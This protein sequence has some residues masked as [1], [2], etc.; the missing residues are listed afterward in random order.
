MSSVNLE[1]SGTL[2]LCPGSSI[3]F[4]CT[5]IQSQSPFI[6]WRVI[7]ENHPKGDLHFF[8][9]TDNVSTTERFVGNFS[10][11]LISTS[12]L[13]STATLTDGFNLEQ[14]ETMLACSD[15]LS[16]N[17]SP[18]QVENATLI[19]KGTFVYTFVCVSLCLLVREREREG[20]NQ[21]SVSM[22]VFFICD[23][24]RL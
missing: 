2:K 19:L 21:V 12:P 7:D 11:A 18:S 10:I 17:Q 6:V 16:L 24:D 15:T 3:T 4:V 13:V 9:K 22:A 23:N 8:T 5:I 20:G 14:N 1:P